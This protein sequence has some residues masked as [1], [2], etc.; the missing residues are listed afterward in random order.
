MDRHEAKR[1]FL[2]KSGDANQ[3]KDVFI[4]S[5]LFMLIG[6]G[7][8]ALFGLGAAFLLIGSIEKGLE[9]IKVNFT[10][11]TWTRKKITGAGD[12]MLDGLDRVRMA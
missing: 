10:P 6:I 8:V 2:H 3:M 4:Q 12:A 7:G 5:G 11:V 1:D 9:S